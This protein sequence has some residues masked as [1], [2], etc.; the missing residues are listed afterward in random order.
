[1]RERH[2]MN[3]LIGK[4]CSGDQMQFPS[5][6]VAMTTASVVSSKRQASMPAASSATGS[7]ESANALMP[8]YLFVLWTLLCFGLLLLCN[9]LSSAAARGYVRD[10]LAALGRAASK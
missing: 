5:M 4:C 7:Q 8:L 10:S 3:R 1:M 9:F 6:G 2:G